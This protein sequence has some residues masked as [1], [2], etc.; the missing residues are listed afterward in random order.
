M[1]WLEA[2]MTQAGRP[3]TERTLF[4][5]GNQNAGKST[6]LRH[7]FVDSRLGTDGK[8]PEA[9]R[10][11]PVTLS[12]ERCLVIR[13]T[14]PH[15]RNETLREFFDKIDHEI[16][17]AFKRFRRFNYACALQ[18]EAAGKMPDLVTTCREFIKRFAPERIRVVLI[19]PRQDGRPGSRLTKGDVD[20]LRSLNVEMAT[21]DAH[22]STPP[23]AYP[24]GIFLADY[25]DFA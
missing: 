7:M 17:R 8:V 1:S 12:P 4:V 14:S 6:L 9:S 24:N 25:F 2:H 21:I 11:E 10:I 18:P 20:K 3:H 13:C 22:K 23:L 19:D 15:E 5:V 16:K